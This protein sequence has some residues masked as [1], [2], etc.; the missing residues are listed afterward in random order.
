MRKALVDLY[1]LQQGLSPDEIKK[2]KDRKENVSTELASLKSSL[3]K[4]SKDLTASEK[5]VAEFEEDESKSYEL[6]KAIETLDKRIEAVCDIWTKLEVVYG[7][8]LELAKSDA[9]KAS[10]DLTTVR[11]RWRDTNDDVTSSQAEVERCQSQRAKMLEKSLS[12]KR[13]S[14][15]TSSV[16]EKRRKS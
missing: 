11:E 13:A 1:A 14:G 10:L 5:A 12:K 9:D 7:R 4:A 15:E 8:Q 6:A 3:E 16:A 2:V